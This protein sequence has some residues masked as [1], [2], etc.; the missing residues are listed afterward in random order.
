M[1][2]HLETE[3]LTL[4]ERQAEALYRV[5]QEALHN[6]LRHAGAD[7]I[8]IRLMR[9]GQE[10]KL[11]IEDDGRGLAKEVEYGLGLRSVK[12][13]AQSL[14]GRLEL[15]SSQGLRLEVTLPNG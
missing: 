2:V 8:W 14:G 10:V 5:A 11:S 1:R 3:P 9:N 6:A 4:K 12:M 13:R 7:N 15:T